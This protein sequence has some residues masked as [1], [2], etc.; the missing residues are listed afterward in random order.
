[1]VGE[2]SI[3]P[4]NWDE[5]YENAEEALKII[6]DSGL[7]DVLKERLEDLLRVEVVS[8]YPDPIQG[9][10]DTMDNI[11][12]ICPPGASVAEVDWL[13]AQVEKLAK[14]NAL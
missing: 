6:W 7:D 5:Y 10:K 13:K 4:I 11:D 1:M 12:G 8:G 3:C 14:G 9:W 2:M